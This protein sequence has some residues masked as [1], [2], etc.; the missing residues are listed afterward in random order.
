MQCT[1]KQRHVAA[2]RSLLKACLWVSKEGK[3]LNQD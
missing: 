3:A 2:N 1:H